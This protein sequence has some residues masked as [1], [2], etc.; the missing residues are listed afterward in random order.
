MAAAGETADGSIRQNDR[1]TKILINDI[2]TEESIK[3]AESMTCDN[4]EEEPHPH[5]LDTE[6]LGE[7]HNGYKRH[8][9]NLVDQTEND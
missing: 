6:I 3:A 4:S 9:K 5:S 7:D 2:S 8:L 1:A